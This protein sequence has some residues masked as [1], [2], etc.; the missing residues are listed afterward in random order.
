ME[1]VQQSRSSAISVLVAESN[2]LNCQLLETALR[3]KHRA[4]DV[5]GS[6]VE[7]RQTL[8]LIEQHKP[9]VV[10]I[11]AQLEGGP[12]EG[13]RVLNGLRSLHTATRAILL[14]D[15]RER[16]LAIDAFR[17]GAHGVIFRDERIETLG[18]CIHAVHQGQVWANS[19]Q[20][21]YL[22]DALCQ[23]MPLNFREGARLDLLSKRQEDVVRLVAQG[24]TNRDVAAKLGLSEHTIRNY[25]FQIFDRVGVSTRVEL[26]LYYLHNVQH[27]AA[28]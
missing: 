6:A 23:S 2:Y 25:L 24:L 8:S 15:S 19:E 3:R 11:S 18:R 16:D 12:L 4:F 22:L 26:V 13:Y 5:I 14:L 21:G 17:C 27:S 9:D 28:D 7:S 10:V 20:L 1:R